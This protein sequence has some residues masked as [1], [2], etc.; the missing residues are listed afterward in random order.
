MKIMK[1]GEIYTADLSPTIG[2]EQDGKRPVVVLQN[3][4]GNKYSTTVIVAPITSRIETKHKLP[5]H[6]PIGEETGV[7]Q[8][9]IVLLEQIR[10]IDKKRIE[11]Y[12]G[13]IEDAQMNKLNEA[14]AISI[15]LGDFLKK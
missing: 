8:P 3:N 14:L 13:K 7:G 4:I 2:S 12:I 1:R 15:D 5:V 10:T 6:F 11:E 9:S